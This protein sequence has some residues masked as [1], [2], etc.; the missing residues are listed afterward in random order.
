MYDGL[1]YRVFEFD[2][3]ILIW[4]DEGEYYLME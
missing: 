4:G 2:N 1:S 3:G